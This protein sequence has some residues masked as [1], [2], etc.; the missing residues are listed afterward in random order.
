MLLTI[1]FLR[2]TVGTERGDFLILVFLTYCVFVYTT[3]S[4]QIGGSVS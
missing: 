3:L 2:V 4:I 1:I